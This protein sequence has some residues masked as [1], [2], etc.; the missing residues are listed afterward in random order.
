MPDSGRNLSPSQ[1][2]FGGDRLRQRTQFRPRL[3]AEGMVDFNPDRVTGSLRII[4]LDPVA[5]FFDTSEWHKEKKNQPQSRRR[6]RSFRAR[7][8]TGNG[9]KEILV[10]QSLRLGDLGFALL[11]IGRLELAGRLTICPAQRCHRDNAA[12]HK[13]FSVKGKLIFDSQVAFNFPSYF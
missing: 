3:T 13:S 7:Q 2:I 4:F 11:C 10:R 12:I 6:Q 1:G 5:A 9:T 8:S